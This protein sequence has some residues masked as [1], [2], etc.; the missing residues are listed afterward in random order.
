MTKKFFVM[1][2]NVVWRGWW[3]FRQG[4][5]NYFTFLMAA[6]NTLT[7]TYFLAIERY[8]IL[9]ALFPNFIQYVLIVASIGIPLLVLVGYAHWKRSSA[10]KAEVDIFY[11]VNP[12]IVRVLVNTEM[13]VQMNLKLNQHILKL[14][15]G[16][17]LSEQE[18]NDLSQLQEKLSEFTKTRKFRNKD[19]W[20]FF[21]NIDTQFKK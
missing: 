11:E 3:Y 13:V 9:V 20:K 1:G 14:N 18:I 17:K 16:Q 4:W 7:I 8:P 10:R 21:S 2:K 15:Q 6:V 5:S 19:D 12:Y